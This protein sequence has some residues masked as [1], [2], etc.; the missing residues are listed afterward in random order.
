M[1]FN[2]GNSQYIHKSIV[3]GHLLRP[4]LRAGGPTSH[5][6]QGCLARRALLT[7][8]AASRAAASQ[9]RQDSNIVHDFVISRPSGKLPG[10]SQK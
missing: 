2:G 3:G 9:A 5:R 1:A 8:V 6:P 7:K 10:A 4:H